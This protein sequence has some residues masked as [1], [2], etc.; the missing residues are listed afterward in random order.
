[1]KKENNK[2]CT[3]KDTHRARMLAM[4]GLFLSNLLDMSVLLGLVSEETILFKILNCVLIVYLT[5]T[6]PMWVIPS[7]KYKVQAEDEMAHENLN[8]AMTLT[9]TTLGVTF[10]ILIAVAYLTDFSME[11]TLNGSFLGTSMLIIFSLFCGF[12]SLFFLLIER[13]YSIS[14]EDEEA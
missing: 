1:M 4:A 12:Q 14:D 2:V 6:L 3:L 13:K 7:T 9:L 8:K 11:I 5:V 10:F